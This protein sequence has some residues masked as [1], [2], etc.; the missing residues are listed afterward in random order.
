[1][2][3]ITFTDYEGTSRDVDA[4]VG[5][6]VMEAAIRNNIPG[7]DADCGGAC[8]CATCHVY[9]APDFLAKTG[10]QE[11]MEQSMLDFADG[12]QENS[13]LS[14]QIQVSEELEGLSVTTP[15][16]QH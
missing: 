7:I 4:N 12:V 3:K 8:A 11:A 6:S 15:E 1:M 13:R 9:V 10:E 14:C 16:S 2:V 5:E